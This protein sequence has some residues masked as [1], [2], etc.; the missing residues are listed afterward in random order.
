[1]FL[2]EKLSDFFFASSQNNIPIFSVRAASIIS[3]LQS[4]LEQF[5]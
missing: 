2:E 3:D 5:A 1:M 4:A